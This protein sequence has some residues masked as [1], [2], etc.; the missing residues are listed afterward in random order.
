MFSAGSIRAPYRALKSLLLALLCCAVI[1]SAQAINKCTDEQ[2]RVAFSDKPCPSE[3]HT[4]R[5]EV[6]VQGAKGGSQATA[7]DEVCHAVFARDTTLDDGTGGYT[8]RAR[9]ATPYPIGGL[10]SH[11]FSTLLYPTE[12][13]VYS[14]IVRTD[15]MPLPFTTTCREHRTQRWL[16]VFEDVT[17][18]SDAAYTLP[19]C[20]LRKG[21]LIPQEMIGSEYTVG[22]G[23][24]GQ[25]KLKFRA[26]MAQCGGRT[27]LYLPMK[28]EMMGRLPVF[29]EKLTSV[30]VPKR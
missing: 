9:M 4:Q 5:I 29:T 21:S 15:G 3:S 14:L 28:L 1:P 20:H 19:V 10:S 23:R 12:G 26:P 6:E 24:T 18:F 17:L 16:A 22:P 27:E 8:Q 11:G 7:F 25:G 30:V 13:G 2:G